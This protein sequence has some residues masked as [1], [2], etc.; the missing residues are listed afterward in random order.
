MLHWQYLFHSEGGVWLA[1][2]LPL[3]GGSG[4][5]QHWSSGEEGGATLSGSAAHVDLHLHWQ[6]LF[7]P[8]TRKR[9]IGVS[10]C[11]EEED[12]NIAP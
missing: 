11:T 7:H 3:G 8:P 9:I 10:V 2:F 1:I 6:Y 4:F 12:H 5:R